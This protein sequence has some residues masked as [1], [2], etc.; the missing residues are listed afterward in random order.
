MKRTVNKRYE[1]DI[2]ALFRNFLTVYICSVFVLLVFGW[3]LSKININVTKGF[4]I[5]CLIIAIP[6]AVYLSFYKHNITVQVTQDGVTF[7]RGKKAYLSLPSRDYMFSSYIH[8]TL[9][10]FGVFTSRY[11]R[12]FEISSARIQN[13]TLVFTSRKDYRLYFSKGDF[14]ELISAVTSLRHGAEQGQLNAEHERPIAER[15]QLSAEHERPIA[16][17][18][19]LGAEHERPIAQRKVLKEEYKQEEDNNTTEDEYQNDR[20]FSINTDEIKA[21]ARKRFKKIMLVYSIICAALL[22]IIV[23]VML[24][25]AVSTKG[26]F[27][28]IAFFSSILLIPFAATMITNYYTL[29]SKPNKMTMPK[30]I[31]IAHDRIEIDGHGYLYK[32]ISR[33]I[34]TPPS[35]VRA[36]RLLTIVNYYGN[37][38]V[39]FIGYGV[40]AK[41][42]MKYANYSVICYVLKQQ[43]ENSAV[44]FLFNL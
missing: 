29:I 20:K 26:A 21:A 2:G 38:S 44:K 19:Q 18:S 22:Y 15:S 11:L 32:D 23:S 28:G 35:Y 34:M 37:E 33:I 31:L 13:K 43:S 3:L 39:F 6:F 16:E 12:A 30:E 40:A 27:I 17:R 1:S 42:T 24:I 36:Y 25:F 8:R 14:E 7:M 4:L 9:S 5:A 41:E 10:M